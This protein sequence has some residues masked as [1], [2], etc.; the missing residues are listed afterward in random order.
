[1]TL[2]ALLLLLSVGQAAFA[3][4]K[5][6]PARTPSNLTLEQAQVLLDRIEKR[7]GEIQSRYDE[8]EPLVEELTDQVRKDR[9][10]G[11]SNPEISGS[12]GMLG[13]DMAGF[14]LLNKHG[15]GIVAKLDL[16]MNKRF[17]DGSSLNIGFG[18]AF[19]PGAYPN[20]VLDDTDE[21]RRGTGTA[22]RLG[23]LL[24]TM[25]M[26]Y[27]K[28]IFSGTAGFQ[29]FQTSVLTLSG[30]LSNRPVV[31]DKNPYM[32][33][34][35]SKAYY[36]NQI[37]TG[38]PKRSPEESEFY[39][40]GLRSDIDLPWDFDLMS[41]LGP[42][43]GFYDNDTV[44]RVYGGVLSFDKRES[45][46][47]KYKLIAF[48]RSNDRPEIDNR[49]GNDLDPY[50]GLMNN[51]VVSLMG[52]QKAGPIALTA[53]L[54]QAAYDDNTG[55]HQTGAAWRGQGDFN[56]GESG[57]HLGAYG[58]APGY[59][60]VDPVGKSQSNGANLVRWRNDPDNKSGVIH[61][62][63]ISDP[64]IPI[65][66]TTTYNTGA[67]IRLGNAFLNINLQNSIQQ[68]PTDSRIWSQHFLSGS[69][70]NGAMWFGMFNNNF[71]SWLPNSAT[72]PAGRYGQPEMEREYF[73]NFRREGPAPAFANTTYPLDS[74]N[75]RY[76]LPNQVSN[77][78]TSFNPGAIPDVNNK[79]Y[80][81]NAYRQLEAG[82]WRQ[83]NEGILVVDKATGKA[84]APSIKGISHASADL[85][86]NLSDYI[87]M[88][89]PV[90][91]QAYGDMTTVSEGAAAF[92]SLD[93]SNLFVQSI[94]DTT[95]IFNVVDPLNL[96][97][98]TG[99]E[100]W[101]SDRTTYHIAR[102]GFMKPQ[103]TTL[104]YHDSCV[105]TGFDWNAIPNK[106]NLYMRVKYLKHHDSFSDENS[107]IARLLELEMKSYF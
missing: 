7:I 91:W 77:T 47:G 17:D 43:E 16:T 80:Y 22:S 56:I 81:N 94:A 58:I 12:Y 20:W 95:L 72:S 78:A 60:V 36:E 85:R 64:T 76:S 44:P 48:N 62:T 70:L 45:I 3:A 29:S 41:F 97:L 18:P 27:K 104:E 55:I 32:T 31:F 24:G 46:G 28:G 14:H 69:N 10:S 54:A 102:N 92:P 34:T 107:F 99:I 61:Q 8:R 6:L 90:F 35:T 30:R 83:N 65:N 38:V 96:M 40:M 51:T 103:W 33:N 19:T 57:F 39:I 2:K 68:T 49:G 50:V 13:R 26:N 82:L 74:Y 67:Q 98:Y 106:L 42:G 52:E 63:N 101:V 75:Q 89:R 53:E 100:N 87:P 4:E 79:L 84:L 93:P 66:N 9:Y 73:N 11:S 5:A 15:V 88:G 23:T 25:K 37:L 105:G 1:M 71:Q 59:V 21:V 86:M